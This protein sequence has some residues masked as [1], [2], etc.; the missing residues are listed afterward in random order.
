[1]QLFEPVAWSEEI[2]AP[3]TAAEVRHLPRLLVASALCLYTGRP[4][5]GVALARAAAALQDQPG[6]EPFEDGWSELLEALAHLF[7]GRIERRVEIC[8]EMVLRTGFAR[9]VGMSGLTWA[10][11]AIGQADE[12]RAIADETLAVAREYGNPFWIGWAMGGYGRAFAET[13]PVAALAVLREGLAY[14]AEHRLVFWQANLAQDAARLEA[15]HGEPADA[16]ELF[17]AAIDEFHRAGNIAFL[18]A[19]LASLAVFFDRV[20]QPEVAATIYGASTRQASIG[21]VPRL[22]DVVV[23]LRTVLGDEAFDRC[24][25][26]GAAQTTGDAV[27]YAHQQLRLAGRA[28]T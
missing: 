19:T 16:L 5:D 6:Y 11:P 27:R 9:V 22:D 2:L 25:A 24:V 23:H 18:A 10:L 1:L 13:D 21:L 8:R 17:A 26:A 14:A 4:D 20:G 15:V 28:R 7:G 12:A 3:A